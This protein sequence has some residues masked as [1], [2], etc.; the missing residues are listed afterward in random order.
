A[1]VARGVD[2]MEVFGAVAEEMRRCVPADTAG[3]WRFESGGANTLVAAAAHPAALAVWPVGTR[4][5]VAGNPLATRVQRTGRPARIDNYDNVTGP[6]AARV[7][8][9]GV[10]AA[11]RSRTLVHGHVRGRAAVGPIQRAEMP[12]D[13]EVRITR[14]AELSASA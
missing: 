12:A 11:L 3:L 6:I 13:T 4:S 14:F 5:P 7:R 10:G 1:W 8:A 2:P 9:V